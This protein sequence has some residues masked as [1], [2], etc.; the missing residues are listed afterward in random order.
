MCLGFSRKKLAL[1]LALVCLVSTSAEPLTAA[2]KKKKDKEAPSAPAVDPVAEAEAKL[3]KELAPVDDQ[4][5]KLLMKVQSRHLL[6]PQEAG[7]LV[8]IKYRLLDFITKNPQSPQLGK[9][10]YQAGVLFSQREEYN[11][12]YEM[13]NYLA[14]GFPATQYGM[15]AR[16]LI[17]QMEK[18]FGTAFFAVEAAVTPPAPTATVADTSASAATASL[19]AAK[20]GAKP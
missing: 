6:S 5:T 10:L 1:L 3:T 15:K 13:F 14:Q 18:R 2:A 8:Q 12:A 19:P 11:D 4:L 9:P 16:G 17:Q 7:Q 20:P